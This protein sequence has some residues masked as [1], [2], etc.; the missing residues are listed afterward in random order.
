MYPRREVRTH[1]PDGVHWK[2]FPICIAM[3][4]E[5][6]GFKNTS[7]NRPF[8]NRRQTLLPGWVGGDF[9]GSLIFLKINYDIKHDVLIPNMVS[10]LTYGCC[11]KSYEH[12][13]YVVEMIY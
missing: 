7:V 5:N 11:V 2:V 8:S 1:S 6:G 12:Y 4:N 3:V 9:F 10:M 13:E